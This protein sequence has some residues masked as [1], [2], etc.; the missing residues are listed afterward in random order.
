[1]EGAKVSYRDLRAPKGDLVGGRAIWTE[2][3]SRG[4]VDRMVSWILVKVAEKNRE[5]RFRR[6][7]KGSLAM[8]VS[9]GLVD[10]KVTPKWK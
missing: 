1:M 10:P 9:R 8:F 6:K 3:S 2:V 7:G 5:N 4:G